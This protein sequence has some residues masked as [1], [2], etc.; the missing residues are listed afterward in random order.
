MPLNEAISI[1]EV[2]QRTLALCRSL[3]PQFSPFQGAIK[4]CQNRLSRGTL[5]LAVMGM[6][7]RGKSSFINSLLGIDLLPTSV[8]PV[9]SIPTTITYGELTKCTVRYFN[10]KPDLCVQESAKAVQDCLVEHVAEENNPLNRRCVD[11]VLVECP[12]PLLKNGT[13]FVDTP[14]FGSTYTHNTKTTLDLLRKCDAVLFLLSPDPPFTLTELEFLKEVRKA[15]PRIFFILNKID[16][17]TVDE[18]IKID[19]FVQSILS[20]TL[21][22]PGDIRVFH[23]SAKMGKSLAGRP[24]NDPAWRLSGMASV[25][26]EIIDFMV[27]EKYF[28]LSQAIVDKFKEALGQ[29]ISLLD[30]ER[31]ELL[32]PAKDAAQDFESIARAVTSIRG[33]IDKELGMMDAEIK[34][35][36]DFAD[37]TINALKADLQRRA[38]ESLRVVL[39]SAPLKKSD[40]PRAVSAGFEQHAGAL[41]DHFFLQVVSAINKPLKKAIALH[42]SE[43]AKLIGD[44]K[45]INPSVSVPD[46][47]LD[48]LGDDLEIKAEPHWKLEGVA[49]AFN[50]IKLPFCGIFASNQTKRQRYRDCF[51]LAIIEIINLNIIRFSMFMN[52][53]IITSC[54]KLKKTISVRSEELLKAAG[55]AQD[56]KKKIVDNLESNLTTRVKELEK[57]KAAFKEIEKLL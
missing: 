23:V 13:M 46:Y 45:Q 8:V 47:D 9:T 16:I 35:F 43:F 2:I 21:G 11:E 6:F 42:I 36:G 53:L 12:Q 52:D 27:R 33:S 20:K 22:F 51:N 56:G 57:Q 14:G 19:R 4:D 1:D 18:L 3:S 48:D 39:E 54:K 32:A 40:L 37:K 49:P 50:Q 31:S 29:I 26:T 15:V 41:F 44:V 30:T 10:G 34:A 7:K 55:K 17:L 24:E 38:S 28:T 5:Y 25:R